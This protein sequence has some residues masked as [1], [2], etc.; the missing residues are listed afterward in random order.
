MPAYSDKQKHFMTMVKAYKK[1]KLDLTGLDQADAIRKAADSMTY[2][3]IEDFI[4]ECKVRQLV[5]EQIK[6]SLNESYM[7][8]KYGQEYEHLYKIAETD[9]LSALLNLVADVC[10]EFDPKVSKQIIK[11]IDGIFPVLSKRDTDNK[12]DMW[13]DHYGR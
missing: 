10:N 4:K 9:G 11:I 8:N 6:K 1:G 13:I 2:D 7:S 5:R 3:E 12:F